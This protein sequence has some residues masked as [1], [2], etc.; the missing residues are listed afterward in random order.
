MIKYKNITISW[1]YFYPYNKFLSPQKS[2]PYNVKN[3]PK[4]RRLNYQIK[5]IINNNIKKDK[6]EDKI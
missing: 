2:I 6:I 1:R 3:I 5:I 4:V